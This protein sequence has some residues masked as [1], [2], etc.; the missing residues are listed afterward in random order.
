MRACLHTAMLVQTEDRELGSDRWSRE[1]HSPWK[2]P[3]QPF[4]WCFRS[5]SPLWKPLIPPP[6]LFFFHP[7]WKDAISFPLRLLWCWVTQRLILE[8]IEIK[9][10]PPF[11][12]GAI[13]SPAHNLLSLLNTG[14]LAAVTY[15]P[16][17]HQEAIF[18]HRKRKWIQISEQELARF[19]MWNDF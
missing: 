9:L 7:S 8:I 17:L 16:S 6:P 5:D 19:K 14:R 3:T 4:L 15:T 10:F 1:M 13:I 12:Q 2:E 11:F 18:L